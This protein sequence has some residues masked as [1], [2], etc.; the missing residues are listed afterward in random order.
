M[1]RDHH[2]VAALVDPDDDGGD[3]GMNDASDEE[4]VGRRLL[5]P[6]PEARLARPAAFAIK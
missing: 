1:T 6:G 5:E 4:E 3:R 2:V